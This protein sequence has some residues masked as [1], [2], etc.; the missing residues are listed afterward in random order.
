MPGMRVTR[1]DDIQRPTDKNMFM[2]VLP[3]REQAQRGAMPGKPRVNVCAWL[4]PREQQLPFPQTPIR[5]SNQSIRR[6]FG[7]PTTYGNRRESAVDVLQIPTISRPRG[8]AFGNT[9][10]LAVMTRASN[11]LIRAGNT[12]T[13]IDVFTGGRRALQ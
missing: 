5:Q 4:I 1:P 12:D 11:A 9:G 13:V 3:C 8:V 10:N 6:A 7:I 2:N